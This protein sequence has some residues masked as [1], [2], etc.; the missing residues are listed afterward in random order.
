MGIKRRNDIR[1]SINKNRSSITMIDPKTTCDVEHGAFELIGELNRFY[2]P[3]YD[4][5]Y[6][7]YRY[8]RMVLTVT[9]HNDNA[10]SGLIIRATDRQ[11]GVQSTIFSNA[12]SGAWTRQSELNNLPTIILQ[13][14]ASRILEITL[15]NFQDDWALGSVFALGGLNIPYVQYFKVKSLINSFRFYAKEGFTIKGKIWGVRI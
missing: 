8:I 9:I 11:D 13:K 4:F 3:Q 2:K 10:T 1:H 6:S 5:D 14:D 15:A 7:M 12:Y